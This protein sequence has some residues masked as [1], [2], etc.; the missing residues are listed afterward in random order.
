MLRLRATFGYNGNVNPAVLARPL[1][2]YSTF[3]GTNNLPY[4]YTDAS[5]GVSNSLLR[6]EKTGIFNVGLDFWRKRQPDLRKCR[7]L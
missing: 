1:I 4:A 2:N 5:S 6:P 3:N 7:I